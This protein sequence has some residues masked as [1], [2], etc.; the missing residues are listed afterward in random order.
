MFFSLCF[1]FDVIYFQFCFV[2]IG[3]SFCC[4]SFLKFCFG[5]C[6]C[7]LY[8]CVCVCFFTGCHQFCFV[9]FFVLFL[10]VKN[11]LFR[12]FAFRL[13]YFPFV[14]Y[15]PPTPHPV[16]F[17]CLFV[18]VVFYVS[19]FFFVVCVRGLFIYVCVCVCCI[20]MCYIFCV[21][22]F[23]FIDLFL[24]V[25]FC[26]FQLVCPFPFFIVQNKKMHCVYVLFVFLF[27]V[28]FAVVIF[29]VLVFVVCLFLVLL[30]LCW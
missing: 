25:Q 24:N 11:I 5:C 20:G 30:L 9:S 12:S 18:F 27:F 28:V 19:A 17:S 16:L 3:S 6:C 7:F 29:V 4:T 22:R 8:V 10:F 13:H 15:P 14:L 26:Q 2:Q 21:C 1:V 23:C